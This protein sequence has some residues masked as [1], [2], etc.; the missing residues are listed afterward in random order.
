M[1]GLVSKRWASSVALRALALTLTTTSAPSLVVKPTA[2]FAWVGWSSG[3]SSGTPGGVVSMGLR[4][5]GLAWPRLPAASVWR[6][7]TVMVSLPSKA[8]ALAV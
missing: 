4:V 3:N 7:L 1:A 8:P 6:A 5:S 2:W